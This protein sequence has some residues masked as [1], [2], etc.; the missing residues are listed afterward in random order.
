MTSATA[1]SDAGARPR[2]EARTL[3]RNAILDA[4]EAVFA[5]RG[6]HAA[7]IQDIAKR[8]RIAVGTVYNHFTQK[9]DVLL[10]LF[11]ERMRDLHAE[12]AGR[13]EDAPEFEAKLHTRLRRML[14]FLDR[15]RSFFAVASE[16]GLTGSTPPGS[17]ATLRG[18]RANPFEQI[19]DD[20]RALVREGIHVGALRAGDEAC[21]TRFLGGTIRA[22]VVGAV[23]DRAQRIE[24]EA[25]VIASLFLR[26]ATSA[27]VRGAGTRKPASR[28]KR[29]ST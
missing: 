7:R 26:G 16:H 12:V 15:H 17:A 20:F 5:E 4:A 25:A 9:D 27:P 19:N 2:D 29:S 28:P 24:D 8:A 6:F 21:L 11:E 1:R 18:C 22:L 3:F 14:G 13:P 23:E 10:A